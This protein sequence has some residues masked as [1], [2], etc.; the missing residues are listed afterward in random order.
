M[1]N[2]ME[3]GPR[4]LSPEQ[5]AKSLGVTRSFLYGRLLQ[6]G[7]LA[8]IKLGKLRRIPVWA[9]DDFILRT[10]AE[11]GIVPPTVSSPAASDKTAALIPPRQ[12][13]KREI[14]SQVGA[15]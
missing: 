12:R 2:R 6:T 7:D 5:A 4:L 13:G 11:Q 1:E 10:A 3:L 9:L 8:S 14:H 15:P